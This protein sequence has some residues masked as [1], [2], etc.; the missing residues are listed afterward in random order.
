MSTLLC[1]TNTARWK[2]IAVEQSRD[3]SGYTDV[4]VYVLH[5]H[6]A[7]SRHV[8]TS[9]TIPTRKAGYTSAQGIHAQRGG[10]ERSEKT[11][12]SQPVAR[13]IMIH[14]TSQEYAGASIEIP[15][16]EIKF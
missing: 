16:L 4:R 3:I 12:G 14:F 13:S 8:H 1:Y 11:D 2:I 15:C 6:R 9:S 5:V 7:V 10:V